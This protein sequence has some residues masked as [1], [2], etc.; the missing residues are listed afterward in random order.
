M[1]GEPPITA[2]PI[3]E[4][5]SVQ[6]VADKVNKFVAAAR[7][8]SLD[9][10]SIAEFA[11]LVIALLRISIEAVDSIPAD[12]QAKKAWVMEALGLL[13]DSVADKCIPTVAYPVWILLRPAARSL[14]MALGSGAV[15]SLLPLVRTAT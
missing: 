10:L 3:A 4:A 7:L 13:F 12:G 8:A 1:P 15:E 9:G 14:V 6:S 11:E 5:A 2:G